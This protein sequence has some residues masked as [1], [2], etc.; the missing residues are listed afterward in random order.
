MKKLFLLCVTFLSLDYAAF[1]QEKGDI[2]VGNSDL[3]LSI[4]PEFAVHANVTGDYFLTG[5]FLWVLKWGLD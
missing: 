4:T 3:H 2:W 1:A 5:N